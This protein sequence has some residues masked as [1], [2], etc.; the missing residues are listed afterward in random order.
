MVWVVCVGF[1]GGLWWFGVV[2]GI[3]MVPLYS[4]SNRSLHRRLCNKTKL[5]VVHVS[6]C[7]LYVLSFVTNNTIFPFIYVKE[8]SLQKIH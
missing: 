6:H 2:C 1:S 8:M 7:K 3:S 4:S 5:P